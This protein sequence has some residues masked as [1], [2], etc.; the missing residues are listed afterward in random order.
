MVAAQLGAVVGVVLTSGPRYGRGR[1][2]SVALQWTSRLLL[3]ALGVRVVTSGL[4]AAGPCLVV[5]NRS[6]WLDVLVLAAHAP[7]VPVAQAR[8]GG[9]PLLGPL[10]RRMRAVFVGGP[11]AG[12]LRG[13]VDQIAQRLRS[14][15]RVLVFPGAARRCG[16]ALERFRCAPFQAAVDAAVVISPAAVSYRDGPGGRL[17]ATN[18]WLPAIP[19]VVSGGHPARD[20]AM[21][22]RR[23]EYAVA[24]SLGRPVARRSA[25]CDAVTALVAF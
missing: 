8:L 4:P 22:A 11:A 5:A 16:G 2:G 9:W 21:A 19:A 10:A 17:T 15:H 7:M 23:T 13:D 25:T 1:R 12:D 24:R 6:S 18:T 3:R 20:R 14:G